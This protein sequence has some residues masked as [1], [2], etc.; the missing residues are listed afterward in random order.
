MSWTLVLIFLYSSGPA[1]TNVRSFLTEADC[2][3]AGL[4]ATTKLTG[5]RKDYVCLKVSSSITTASD[6]PS[7]HLFISHRK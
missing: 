7:R 2:E 3:A 1:T 6:K 4:K 5:I